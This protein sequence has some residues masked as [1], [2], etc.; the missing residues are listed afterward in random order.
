M[1][2]VQQEPI[3]QPLNIQ[4]PA[5]L[6]DIYKRIRGAGKDFYVVG[7]AVRDALLGKSPKD[8]DM[9]T[10]ATPDQVIKILKSHGRLRLDLTGKSFGVV[11]VKTPDDNEYEIATFREDIGKGRRPDAV[12]FTSIEGDV[13][14][15][16]LTV[17]AL[18]YDIAK[19][20]VVDY[21]GGI[22]DIEKGVI[23]A[24]GNPA[25]RFDEDKL[26]VLRAVRFAG[27]MGSE[28]DDETA[29]A[30][31]KDPYL[32]GVSADRISEEFK[33]GISQAMQVP[34]FL[35]IM[36]GLGLFEEIFP[37]L[38]VTPD[39]GQTK[40]IPAQLALLLRDN[41]PMEVS[42]VLK[43]MRYTGDETKLSTFLIKLM[44]ISPETAPSLKSQFKK[45][46]DAAQ[47]SI[48]ELAKED[49]FHPNDYVADGFLQ[50]AQS[51][52]AANPREL[53]AQGLKGPDIGKAMEDA[54]R[55]AYLNLI[56]EATLRSC[57]RQ[58]LV[59]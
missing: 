41:D 28:L 55:Q 18:F 17:N 35:S 52:P 11:R 3:R 53:M 5:D 46:P 26:R 7:G 40:D 4:L 33:K 25:D 15:R 8:Y 22:Q 23:R 21:V 51:P 31:R 36:H 56:G 14:R 2:G 9:A 29:D 20:E 50:F 37:D 47:A 27:R 57:I 6:M 34:H 44:D 10:D 43:G 48:G 16:D 24:V 45:F 38:Q 58:M 39:F 13:K 32:E 59:D 49:A 54:E 12:S 1:S 30:I 19:G 42:S